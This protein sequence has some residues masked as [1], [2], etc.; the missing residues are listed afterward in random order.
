[1]STEISIV[2]EPLLTAGGLTPA[3][4]GMHWDQ[5][6][7]QAKSFHEKTGKHLFM[8]RLGEI[9]LLDMI[10]A[11]GLQPIERQSGGFRS[12]LLQPQIVDLMQTWVLA[13][14]DGTLP[15]ESA[16]AGYAETV[17]AF[18]EQRIALLNADAVRSI[19]DDSPS[20]YES[21]LVRP[22]ITGTID[23]TNV[24]AADVAVSAQ[25]APSA[26]GRGARVVYDQSGVAGAVVRAGQP[27]AEHEGV[28]IVACVF[29]A[30]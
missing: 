21:L 18:K 27:R 4:L 23:K 9:D 2:N 5:L 15:R 10:I 1:M 6:L 7:A 3:T 13:V 16:T 14:R 17:A 29:A 30:N 19:R 20:L 22:G 8:L 26:T 25:S 24:S 28:T 12:N 11:Q